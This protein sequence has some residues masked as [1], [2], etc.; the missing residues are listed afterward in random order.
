MADY[1]CSCIDVLSARGFNPIQKWMVRKQVS[2]SENGKTYSLP[3]VPPKNSA[4]YQIDGEIISEGRKC[5]KLVVVVDNPIN[6]SIFVELKGKD[7]RHAIDQ[8]ESTLNH[9]LFRKKNNNKDVIR[10]RIVTL[11]SG[12]ASS[13]SK[14]VTEA[15]ARFMRKYNC[16]L[17][18]LKSR[19]PDIPF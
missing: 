14:F 6:G 19:Q 13:S 4:V 12:P 18:I 1:T 16:D 10:A 8:L 7:I 11:S 3:L 15:R 5:D 2:V 17:R 9:Q